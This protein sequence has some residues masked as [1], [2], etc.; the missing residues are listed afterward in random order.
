MGLRCHEAGLPA[1]HVVRRAGV[2]CTSPAR[3]LVDLTRRG[4]LGSGLGFI[5]AALHAG[6]VREDELTLVVRDCRGWPG[7]RRAATAVDLADPAAESP[8]ESQSRLYVYQRGLPPP[9]TQQVITV[10]G[11]DC[12]RVDFLW[13]PQRVIGGPTG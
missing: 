2:R 9:L 10:P 8:L 6:L 13:L 3:T 12:Y 1:H 11:G 7:I 5:D 4:S